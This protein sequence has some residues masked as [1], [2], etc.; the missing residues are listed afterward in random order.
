[1]VDENLLKSNEKTGEKEQ[2]E[3]GRAAVKKARPGKKNL[4]RHGGNKKTAYQGN[5][6]DRVQTQTREGPKFYPRV[7][8]CRKHTGRNFEDGETELRVGR[9]KLLGTRT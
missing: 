8:G 6:V 9:K 1:M 7:G 3:Q 5:G 2:A 4:S